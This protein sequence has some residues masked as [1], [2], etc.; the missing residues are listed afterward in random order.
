MGSSMP[1]E[2]S[3]FSIYIIEILGFL[4]RMRLKAHVRFSGRFLVLKQ[5]NF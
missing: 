1:I 5:I 2:N 4:S 3:I